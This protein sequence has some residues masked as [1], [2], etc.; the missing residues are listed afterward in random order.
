MHLP[1]LQYLCVGSF[2]IIAEN[3]KVSAVGLVGLICI[4]ES[5][6]QLK[7][8][9]LGKEFFYEGENHIGNMGVKLLIKAELPQLR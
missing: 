3:N 2:G 8:L 9:F 4:K 7:D 5:A 1:Q 6:S